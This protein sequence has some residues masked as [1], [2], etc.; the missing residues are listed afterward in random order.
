MT[1]TKQIHSMS[2][3]LRNHK[4]HLAR[5][6]ET[7]APEV[8]TVYGRAEVVMLDAESY[9]NLMDRFRAMEA[10]TK[11]RAEFLRLKL[12]STSP[13]APLPNEEI[14]RRNHVLDEL[15]AETERLGLYK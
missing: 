4:A 9:E 1:D 3:F 14:E 10:I 8:L 15:V 13:A 5:L 6:K 12:N 2:D 11:T 7:R